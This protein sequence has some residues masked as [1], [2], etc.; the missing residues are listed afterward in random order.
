[1]FSL[2]EILKDNY[3]LNASQHLIMFHPITYL[4]EEFN[5][6]YNFVVHVDLTLVP[7]QFDV[8]VCASGL[9]L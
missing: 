5:K 2:P 8:T 1:M 4:M 3:Y 9:N 6:A 7:Y